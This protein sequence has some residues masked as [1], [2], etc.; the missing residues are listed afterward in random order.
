MRG[1]F[2]YN[3]VRQYYEPCRV[4]VG[5]GGVLLS[6]GMGSVVTTMVRP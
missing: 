2:F 4:D 6:D 5:W 1:G 3:Y